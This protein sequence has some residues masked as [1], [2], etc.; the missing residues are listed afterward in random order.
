MNWLLIAFLAP[1]LWAVS[2]FIDKAL[3]NK[4][5]KGKIGALIIYSCLIGLPVA[6]LIFLF[7]PEVINLDFKTALLVILNSGFYILYLFPYLYALKGEDTSAVSPIF[8]II[9]VFTFILAFF[10]LGE[11]LSNLQVLGGILIIAGAI[12]ISSNFKGRKIHIKKKVLG[13]MLLAS[14]LIAIN[15]VLFKFFAIELDFWTTSFWQYLGFFLL[16]LILLIFV[17]KYRVDFMSAAKQNKVG[18]ISTNIVNEV[19]NIIAVIIFSYATLLAPVALVGLVNGFQPF[20]VFLL[21]IMI[22][23]I[24][25]RLIKEDLSKKKLIQKIIFIVILFIGAALL[26]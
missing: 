19:I 22:T 13:L 5:F 20:F 9:P 4:Y 2:T 3:L 8:Q 11:I 15:R 12:G 21:G 10:I 23:L 7:K 26:I 24:A 6:L 1:L 25:P 17:K 18:I 16:G 14:L